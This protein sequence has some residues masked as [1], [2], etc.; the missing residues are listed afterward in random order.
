MNKY[1]MSNGNILFM[2]ELADYPTAGFELTKA[3]SLRLTWPKLT[4]FTNIISPREIHVSCRKRIN[5][6]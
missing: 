5:A 6:C 3:S 4:M 2:V 1:T